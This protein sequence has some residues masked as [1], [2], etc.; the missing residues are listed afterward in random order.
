MAV[1]LHQRLAGLRLRQIKPVALPVEEFVD[2]EA[3]PLQALGA[4]VIRE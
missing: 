2:H 3:L 1:N 4:R